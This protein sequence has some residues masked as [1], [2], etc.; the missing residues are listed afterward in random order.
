MKKLLV[1]LMIAGLALPVFA[2]DEPLEK[3]FP[4]VSRAQ[5]HRRLLTP[6]SEFEPEHNDPP[7]YYDPNGGGISSAWS[8]CKTQMA[9]S[10]STY[11]DCYERTYS[12]CQSRLSGSGDPCQSC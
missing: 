12:R 1:L 2:A 4:K 3:P 11:G 7:P 5:A 8:G 10:I 6:V 9:C